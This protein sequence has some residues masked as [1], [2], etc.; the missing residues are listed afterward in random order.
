MA[1][2]VLSENDVVTTELYDQVKAK[3]DIENNP[4]E[5]MILHTA[6]SA[7]NGWVNFDVW[8]SK[9]A[10]EAFDRDRLMPAIQAVAAAA[11]MEPSPPRRQ[12]VYE[13][14]DLIR[15]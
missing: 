14:H 5:G 1:V 3:M 8:E 13:L 9:E 11:G 7:A 4:P 15:A 2:A 6:G 10:F 12:E